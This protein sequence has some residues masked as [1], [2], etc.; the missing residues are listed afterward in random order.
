MDKLMKIF[1]PINIVSI[2]TCTIIY[3]L[4]ELPYVYAWFPLPL[5]FL[6]S[7]I[8]TVPKKYSIIRFFIWLWLATFFFPVIGY[9]VLVILDGLGI[10]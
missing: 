4:T 5:A 9:F 2:L 1:L 6:I 8:L 7:L 10:S 3:N